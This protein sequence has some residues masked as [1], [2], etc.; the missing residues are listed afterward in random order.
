MALVGYS[1]G[2]CF[3]LLQKTEVAE[4]IIEWIIAALLPIAPHQY[5]IPATQ[6]QGAA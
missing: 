3:L 6:A 2:F 1:Q 5:P 4:K